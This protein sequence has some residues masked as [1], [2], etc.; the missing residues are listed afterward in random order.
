MHDR[1]LRI[2]KL[3]PIALALCETCKMEFHSLERLEEAAEREMRTLFTN[4]QCGKAVALKR[5]AADA[6]ES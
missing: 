5:H 1:T 2:I 3:T 4:H 6:G